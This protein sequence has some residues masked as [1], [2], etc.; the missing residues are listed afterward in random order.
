M[1]DDPGPHHVQIDVHQAACQMLPGLNRC[2]MIP[3]LPERTRTPLA[4]VERLC[5][6]ALDQL[7]AGSDLVATL[8]THQQMDVL[9]GAVGYV[10]W[11]A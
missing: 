2:G 5:R 3:V 7:H 1:T 8:I 4:T 11:V 10:Q 6:T 9:W